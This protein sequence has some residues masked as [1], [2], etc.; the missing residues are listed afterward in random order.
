MGKQYIVNAKLGKIDFSD[1]EPFIDGIT[2]LRIPGGTIAMQ[3]LRHHYKDEEVDALVAFQNL[4]GC[5]CIYVVNGNDTPQ[6]QD[7][8]IKYLKGRGVKF[9]K[10]EIF[11]EV[12]LQ[13][14]RFGD[15]SKPEVT[16]TITPQIYTADAELFITAL[17][18][19]NLPF[20]VCAAHHQS[21]GIGHDAYKQNWNVVIKAWADNRN[22]IAGVTFH[23]YVGREADDSDL[24]ISNFDYLNDFSDYQILITEC[25]SYSTNIQDHYDFWTA[26][27]S[28]LKPNDIFGIHVLWHKTPGHH[29]A[30]YT[31]AGIS[32]IG[33]KFQEF[34]S[35]NVV[36][37]P[38]APPPPPPPPPKPVVVI[39]EIRFTINLRGKQ[40]VFFSDGTFVWTPWLWSW[41]QLGQD[42][43]GQDREVLKT[44]MKKK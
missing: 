28:A 29:H 5:Q 31:S 24:S 13:K 40:M 3:F 4:H 20:Y 23:Q 25:G 11:N 27:S 1:C 9:V 14:F 39:T 33:I 43:V 19:H 38:P 42:L 15:T 21:T 30:L 8:I 18:H 22:D 37:E 34:V 35:D 26:F 44:L 17:A 2:L 7:D 10:I 32:Q 16:K 6:N 12:Y 41:E 36:V